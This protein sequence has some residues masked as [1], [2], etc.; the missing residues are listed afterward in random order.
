M[1]IH[2]VLHPPQGRFYGVLGKQGAALLFKVWVSQ[3]VGVDLFQ[4][5]ALF[6]LSS[7]TGYR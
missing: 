2:Q 1:P 4:S 7:V 3:S 6:I 5:L